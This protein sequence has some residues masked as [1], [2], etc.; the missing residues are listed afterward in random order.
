MKR[1]AI[2]NICL[3]LTMVSS[4]AQTVLETYDVNDDKQT[5][6]IVRDSVESDRDIL[7]KLDLDDY[8]VGEEVFITDEMWTTMQK[9]Q[10]KT[11]DN[12]LTNP[13]VKAETAQV[14]MVQEKVAVQVAA[15]P[16]KTTKAKNSSS[17]KTTKKKKRRKGR[18]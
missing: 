5:T 10:E 3:L 8:T 16:A 15:K 12:K 6:V 11:P 4:F 9:K 14:V 1:L 2:L 18:E 13:V 17:K 7:D